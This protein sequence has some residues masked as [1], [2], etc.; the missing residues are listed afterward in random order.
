[1][2][3]NHDDRRCVSA[4]KVGNDV[5]RGG[6]REGDV[7]HHPDLHALGGVQLLRCDRVNE[8]ARSHACAREYESE[9][10]GAFTYDSASVAE[11]IRRNVHRRTQVAAQREVVTHQ[12]ATA[13][14]PHQALN[15]WATALCVACRER[16]RES[17]AIYVRVHDQKTAGVVLREAVNESRM[18]V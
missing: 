14:Q 1:M 18:R 16:E 2:R 4:R 13:A 17:G 3:A 15:M 6:I 9:R 8:R 10:I 12:W 7:R 11:V 5:A